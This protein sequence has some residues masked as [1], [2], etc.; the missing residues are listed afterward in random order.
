MAQLAAEVMIAEA[1]QVLRNAAPVRV[2]RRGGPDSCVATRLGRVV[3][4][5]ELDRVLAGGGL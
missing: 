1:V 3:E 2:D 4:C 5:G